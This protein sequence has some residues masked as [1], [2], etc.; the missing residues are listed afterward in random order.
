MDANRYRNEAFGFSAGIPEGWIHYAEP[1]DDRK[2]RI[3]ARIK[4]EGPPV[5]ADSASKGIIVASG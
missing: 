1:I 4:T 2:Q 3:D 5:L